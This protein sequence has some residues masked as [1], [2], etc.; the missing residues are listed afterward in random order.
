MLQD[1]EQFAASVAGLL[2]SR[3]RHE[4][5]ET[6]EPVM[7]HLT[8]LGSGEPDD[9]PYLYMLVAHF[10]QKHSRYVSLIRGGFKAMHAHPR[11]NHIII[12]HESSVCSEC[13]PFGASS[14]IPPSISHDALKDMGNAFMNRFSSAVRV[15]SSSVKD[16]LGKLLQ[17]PAAAPAVERHVSPSDKVTRPYRGMAPSVFSIGDG[18]EEED[19]E[20]APSDGMAGEGSGQQATEVVHVRTMSQSPEVLHSFQCQEIVT[21]DAKLVPC[22]LMLTST[23]LF[24]LHELNHRPAY[25]A[26]QS[27]RPLNT[28]VKITSKKRR[29]EVITLKYGSGVADLSGQVEE[30]QIWDSNR[31]FIPNPAHVTASIKQLIVQLLDAINQPSPVHSASS[32]KH[33]T[34]LPDVPVQS[35]SVDTHDCDPNGIECDPIECDS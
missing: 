28:I 12:D 3:T 15:Q 4:G 8:F 19:E 20:E 22:Y 21:A 31:F 24:I 26:V 35:P 25:A 23:H 14:A 2:A 27:R 10:L 30:V 6:E 17:D 33:S 9:E 5:D 34:P 7:D 1:P 18:D 32:P 11:F 16:K 29:P 13:L